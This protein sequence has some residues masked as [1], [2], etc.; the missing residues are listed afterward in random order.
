MF[1][2]GVLA[3]ITVLT[4][5]VFR[6]AVVRRAARL[7]TQLSGGPILAE[8]P[9]C[10]P[11]S[12]DAIPCPTASCVGILDHATGGVEDEGGTAAI[13]VGRHRGDAGMGRVAGPGE[14]NPG[15]LD[16]VHE[17]SGR[18]VAHNK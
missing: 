15:L 10:R 14:G 6:L 17:L 1:T 8:D 3:S 5:L 11:G 16:V 7:R 9:S 4:S 18:I 2:S 13:L 12:Q